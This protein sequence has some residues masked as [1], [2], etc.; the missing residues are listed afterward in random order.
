MMQVRD[1]QARWSVA[2]SDVLMV[3]GPPTALGELPH[4]D[5]QLPMLQ[6]QQ[7]VGL[8]FET[9]SRITASR[10]R[11]MAPVSLLPHGSTFPS[12]WQLQQVQA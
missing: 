11:D 8:H 9:T 6:P 1:A 2:G 4:Q 7:C 10:S 3:Q 5:G 12:G